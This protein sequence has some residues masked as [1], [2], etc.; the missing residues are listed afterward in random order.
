MGR[1][2]L[3][4]RGV[5]LSWSGWWPL[6]LGPSQW[7]VDRAHCKILRVYLAVLDVERGSRRAAIQMHCEVL[8][9]VSEYVDAILLHLDVW[10]VPPVAFKSV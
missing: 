3:I 8:I 2:S 9:V 6:N 10:L 1:W 5:G 7:L 4:D